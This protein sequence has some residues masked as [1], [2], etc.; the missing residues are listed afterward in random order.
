MPG[1]RAVVG[2]FLVATAIVGLFAAYASA[3]AAPSTRWLVAARD[4]PVGATLTRT[5]LGTVTAELP[6]AVAAGAF[7]RD[8]L[9]TVVGRVTVGP[10]GAGEL[11]QGAALAPAARVPDA[12]VMTL[13]VPGSRAPGDLR[14]GTPVD[15]VATYGR[16]DGAYAAYVVRGT[17]VLDVATE[18]G[19]LGGGAVVLTLAVPT[20]DEV[21]ALAHAAERAEVF[22]TR[23]TDPGDTTLPPA[24]RPAV[25]DTLAPEAPR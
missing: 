15:V 4:L 12:E 5:D 8:R 11:V 18:D 9:D 14:P 3:T 22:V 10:V 19:A 16:T 23:A 17:T 24:F 25:P 2:A 13:P 6:E 20:P 1:R 21:L 7:R